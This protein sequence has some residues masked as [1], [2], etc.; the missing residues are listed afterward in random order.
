MVLIDDEETAVAL[1]TL[2]NRFELVNFD[3]MAARFHL[4]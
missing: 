4:I 2:K 1:P 3:E